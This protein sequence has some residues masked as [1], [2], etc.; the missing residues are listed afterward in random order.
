MPEKFKFEQE[1]LFRTSSKVLNSMV[2]TPSGLS[3]WFADDVNIKDDIYTF[4]WNGSEEVARLISKKAN[5]HIK[6]QWLEDEEEG[7]DT[8][9]EIRFK[10]DPMTKAV[11]LHLTSFAEKDEMEEIQLYWESTIEELRRVI[12]A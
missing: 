4:Y 7:L 10:V 12:G 5:D 1:Y 3:E 2:M 6:F 8:Y 11:V 9:V